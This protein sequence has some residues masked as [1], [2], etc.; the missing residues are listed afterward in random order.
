M[1]IGWLARITKSDPT[2]WLVSDLYH[3]THEELDALAKLMGIGVAGRTKEGKIDRIWDIREIRLKLTRYAGD[4]DQAQVQALAADYLGK[5]LKAMLRTIGIYAPS[6]KY[7]MAAALL[8]W[9]NA[10]R[11]RGQQIL[12]LARNEASTRPRQET[13]DFT[14]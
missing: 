13:L 1:S 4:D 14:W 7:G 9:R 10:C 8:N 3:L 12:K 11:M 5:D 2:T 6:T